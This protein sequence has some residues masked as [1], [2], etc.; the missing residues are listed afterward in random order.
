MKH[1]YIFPD[2]LAKSMAKVDVRTQYEAGMLSM[3]LMMIGL[4]VTGFY[5]V[6]Y[7]ELALW[8][9]IFLCINIFAGLVFFWSNLVTQYQQYLNYMEVND[10]QM[11]L[12]KGGI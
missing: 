3:A 12:L 1:N 7:T 6:A 10:F 2:I 4:L 9:K 8:Y 5:L 11:K